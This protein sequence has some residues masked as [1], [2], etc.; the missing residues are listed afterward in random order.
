[1]AYDWPK[2]WNGTRTA[3]A[4]QQWICETLSVP[5]YAVRCT[6]VGDGKQPD[7]VVGT[8]V[9]IF[10]PLTGKRTELVHE[11]FGRLVGFAKYRLC[12][13]IATERVGEHTYR[14]TRVY[15]WRP[16]GD[17]GDD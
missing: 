4:V 5:K 17:N 3:R 7:G 9:Q 2:G 6:I 8:T 13:D 10:K 16:S 1:M 12:V 14:T 11:V 15:V